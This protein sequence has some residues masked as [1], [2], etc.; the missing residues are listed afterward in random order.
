MIM[1]EGASRAPYVAPSKASRSSE[2]EGEGMAFLAFLL[3][4]LLGTVVGGPLRIEDRP[5]MV[6]TA[7]ARAS[8]IVPWVDNASRQLPQ[9]DPTTTTNTNTNTACRHRRQHV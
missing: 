9:V 1:H 5:F 2:G 6:I 7:P 8:C 3:P 4:M